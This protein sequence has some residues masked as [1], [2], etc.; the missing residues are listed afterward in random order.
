MPSPL[1]AAAG[2][3]RALVFPTLCL[4]CDRRMPEGD[5]PARERIPLCP[6]CLRRLV[7]PDPDAARARLA[8]LPAEAP[9]P[10]RVT[11]LWTLDPGGAI[12]RL[13]HALK[14]GGRPD[15]GVALGRLVGRAVVDAEGA[16]LYDA[17][18]PVPLG[19][20]RQL[21][22]GYNQAEW[23]A[24]GLVTAF[25]APPPVEGVALRA[26]ATRSQTTLSRTRRW[27]NVA[28]AFAVAPGAAALDGRRILLVD[29]VL[30]TGATVRAAASAL[31]QAG[32]H[33]VEVLALAR[34]FSL[35]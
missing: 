29:D 20:A 6:S 31:R 16:P 13:H 1:A 14:Y 30:T 19:R 12:R 15:L 33:R 2:A 3:L 35:A 7:R 8:L 34:A 22:R 4:G 27:T 21:E 10:G 25:D 9:R 11:A 17:V 18:V 5:G 32:A 26:R 24:Q 23:L 28:G